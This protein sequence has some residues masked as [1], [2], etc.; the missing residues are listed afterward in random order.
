[1]K[2]CFNSKSWRKIVY[3]FPVASVKSQDQFG[4]KGQSNNGEVRM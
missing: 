1:M 3:T 2:E 4:K